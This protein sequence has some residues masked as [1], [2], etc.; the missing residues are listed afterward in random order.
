MPPASPEQAWSSRAWRSSRPRTRPG[1]VVA[2]APLLR[3]RQSRY[4]WRLGNPGTAPL[5]TP[6]VWLSATQVGV[7]FVGPGPP[8]PA[9]GPDHAHPATAV[10]PPAGGA[11]RAGPR[12]SHAGRRAPA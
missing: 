9:K 4:A 12:T 2:Q 8:A 11:P 7:D 1:F 5:W 6:P 10:R 3:R